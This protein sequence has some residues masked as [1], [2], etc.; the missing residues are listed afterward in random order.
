MRFVI[1]CGDRKVILFFVT[2]KEF[3][4]PRSYSSKKFKFQIRPSSF[5]LSTQTTGDCPVS[6]TSLK[7]LLQVSLP[8]SAIPLLIQPI[9]PSVYLLHSNP[10]RMAHWVPFPCPGHCHS[11]WTEKRKHLNSCVSSSSSCFFA[12]ECLEFFPINMFI[13]QHWK[14]SAVFFSS[15]YSQPNYTKSKFQ[16]KSFV[17]LVFLFL[18]NSRWI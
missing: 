6:L 4:P 8:H 17:F 3:K 13:R 5:V 16:T 15:E 1:L 11:T 7:I 14:W 2:F 10:S 9:F 18:E 12:R